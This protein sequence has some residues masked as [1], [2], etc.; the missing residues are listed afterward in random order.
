MLPFLKNKIQSPG[1]IT[2]QRTP[3][4]PAEDT[5]DNGL[6]ACAS[7]LIHAVHAKDTS[8]VVAALKAIVEILDSQPEEEQKDDSGEQE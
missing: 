4:Q 1:I 8:G 6:E 5:D 2:Q 7:D 3:D